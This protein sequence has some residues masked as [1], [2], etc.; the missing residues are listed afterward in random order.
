MDQDK[1]KRTSQRPRSSGSVE[2]TAKR[3]TAKG[4][5]SKVAPKS[6]RRP[7]ATQ[8]KAA[9]KTGKSES[10]A[11]RKPVKRDSPTRRRPASEPVKKAAPGASSHKRRPA[12]PAQPAPEVVYTPA[13]PFNRG[14]LVLHLATVVAVVLALSF[15]IS[16]FFKVE[17]I[18]VSGAEKYDVWTVKEASGIEIGDNLLSFGEAKAAGKIKTALPYVQSVR[19]GIKLPDTVNIEIKELD[20][21]YAI[22]DAGEQWWLITSGGRVI[23]KADSATAGDYTQVLGVKLGSPVAGQQAMA[24]EEAPPEETTIDV[25]GLP[26]M[27][28]VVKA[29]DR[30]EAA[31]SILQYL[32]ECSIIGEA[33]SINVEDLGNMELQYGRRFLVKLGDTTQLLYKIK[34]MNAA[35]NGKDELNSLKE[36]DSGVL[37]VS[38]TIKENQVIY[39]ASEE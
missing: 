8:R 18:T 39:Q 3:T 31:L 13:K 15:G 21:V 10:T 1:T 25:L 4:S 29:S 7:A 11:A 12:A 35:I 19:I 34:C 6:G 28:P 36:Y 2:G 23:D 9:Q 24:Q 20:V 26:T 14:K 38:F 33:A 37:D 17:V 27:A 5:G 32:E 30:L 22:K 16:I